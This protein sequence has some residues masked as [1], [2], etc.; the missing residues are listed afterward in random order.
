MQ[1]LPGFNR[2]A[3]DARTTPVAADK[4]RQQSG[5]IKLAAQVRAGTRDNQRISGS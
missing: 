5:A 1:L 3:W 4:S 2:H